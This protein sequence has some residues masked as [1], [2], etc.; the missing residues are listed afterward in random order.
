MTYD[1][2][3]EYVRE[4]IQRGISRDPAINDPGDVDYEEK[5]VAK[6]LALAL[7]VEGFRIPHP[8]DGA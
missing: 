1:Q 8:D 5:G 7:R 2:F 3:E 4:A 6:A